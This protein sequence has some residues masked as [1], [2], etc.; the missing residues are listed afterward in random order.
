MAQN[1]PKKVENEPE[2]HAHRVAVHRADPLE[3]H[4]RERVRLRPELR[5]LSDINL[6]SRKGVKFDKFVKFGFSV[7]TTGGKFQIGKDETL[8]S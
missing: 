8:L 5:G 3:A 2:R 6:C 7:C 1:S 4:A